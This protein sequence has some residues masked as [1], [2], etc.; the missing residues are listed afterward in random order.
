MRTTHAVRFRL[1]T[2]EKR[3]SFNASS[4]A[5]IAQSTDLNFFYTTCQAAC[6]A[7]SVFWT[8][9]LSRFLAGE[10]GDDMPVPMSMAVRGMW[11]GVVL[12]SGRQVMVGTGGK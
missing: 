3:I 9:A 11:R 5:T 7:T 4:K 10:G 1:V 2:L 12:T 8:F 6:L